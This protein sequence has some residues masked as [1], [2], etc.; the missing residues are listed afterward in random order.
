MKA[1]TFG[2][3]SLELVELIGSKLEDAAD[4]A[5]L[6]AT[7][8]VARAASRQPRSRWWDAPAVVAHLPLD[9]DFDDEEPS[10]RMQL[11]MRAETMRLPSCRA[12][13]VDVLT[14]HYNDLIDDYV[15]GPMPATLC[16]MPALRHLN[17]TTCD[18]LRAGWRW[19][20]LESLRVTS[21]E[22]LYDIDR[23][24]D[25]IEVDMRGAPRLRRVAIAC[26]EHPDR[27]P[28]YSH[29]TSLRMPP[30][31]ASLSLRMLVLDDV[32]TL[33]QA[34]ADCPNLRELRVEQLAVRRDQV[35]DDDS[36]RFLRVDHLRKLESLAVVDPSAL[37]LDVLP[38]GLTSL[39]LG[40]RPWRTR[41]VMGRFDFVRPVDRI[42]AA[43]APR[44][45]RVLFHNCLVCFGP[46]EAAEHLDA[47]Y[48][49]L[50]SLTVTADRPLPA[51]ISDP[52]A[53]PF[54]L[55]RFTRLETLCLRNVSYPAMPPRVANQWCTVTEKPVSPDYTD[56]GSDDEG[57][58]SGSDDEGGDPGSDS[59]SDDEGGD[60]G[61]D[62][63]SDN[64][65]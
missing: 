55:P 11:M 28:L 25:S 44:L 37:A 17:L 29:I 8:R 36:M 41:Q 33:E 42:G 58:D 18:S 19:P 63:G 60:S 51:G 21:R 45:S 10:G 3:L 12:A 59:G 38:R 54:D 62:S 32:A 40:G 65:E 20:A 50:T 23:D 1:A 56:P 46:A 39:E 52:M 15:R 31:L 49:Q 16:A 48:R 14:G 27:V 6:S 26:W 5:N 34:L 9:E 57:G 47:L 61:S 64:D 24:N 2:S 7:C 13:Y 4:K 35:V 43:T 30:S 22:L 53:P